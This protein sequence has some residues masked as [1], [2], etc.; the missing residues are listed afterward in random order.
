MKT[1]YSDR[2]ISIARLNAKIYSQRVNLINYEN[3]VKEKNEEIKKLQI[4][5][6]MA[7]NGLFEICNNPSPDFN[8]ISY[9]R[10]VWHK[11]KELKDD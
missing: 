6:K 8:R 4:Q 2:T 3:L 11:V 10:E 7:M 1:P 5:L 9:A